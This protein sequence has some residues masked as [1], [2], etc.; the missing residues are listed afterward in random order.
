MQ[1]GARLFRLRKTLGLSADDMAAALG[2]TGAH[3]KSKLHKM[4]INTR[5][6]SPSCLDKIERMEREAGINLQKNER[7]SNDGA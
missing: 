5:D 1:H 6:I 4:E 7:A 2:F 3:R